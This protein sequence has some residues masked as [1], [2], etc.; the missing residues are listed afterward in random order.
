VGIPI[1]ERDPST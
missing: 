1:I